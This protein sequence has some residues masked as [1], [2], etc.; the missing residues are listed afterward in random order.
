MM[1]N[2]DSINVSDL[3]RLT[4]V[5]E[6]RFTINLGDTTKLDYKIASIKAVIKKLG[7]YDQGYLDASFTTYPQEVLFDNTSDTKN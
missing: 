4:L 6:D 3:S 7:D 1:G 5:Y 2:V